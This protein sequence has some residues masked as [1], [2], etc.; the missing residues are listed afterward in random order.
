[1]GIH[2][3]ESMDFQKIRSNVSIIQEIPFICRFTVCFVSHVEIK[4]RGLFA[5]ITYSVHQAEDPTLELG[6][7]PP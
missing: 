3:E 5:R 2:L 7:F 6:L 4:V 1:M